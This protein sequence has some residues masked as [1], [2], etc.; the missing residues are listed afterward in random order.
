MKIAKRSSAVCV[1]RF[2]KLAGE[3]VIVIDLR[4]PR[5]IEAEFLEMRGWN[6]YQRFVVQVFTKFIDVSLAPERNVAIYSRLP[7]SLRDAVIALAA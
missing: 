3:N 1:H 4:E 7:Q 6:F 5:R 2:A